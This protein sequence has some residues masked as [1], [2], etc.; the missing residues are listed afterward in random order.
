MK[1]LKHGVSS[2]LDL[3]TVVNL[4]T[5]VVIVLCH[6]GR[7]H[8]CGYQKLRSSPPKRVRTRSDAPS[9]ARRPFLDI[10]SRIL[11]L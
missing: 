3:I 5:D 9:M 10:L 11:S 6:R 1:E 8:R 2:S 7:R 4:V